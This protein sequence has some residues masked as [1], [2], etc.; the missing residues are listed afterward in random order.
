MVD[1]TSSPHAEIYW[2]DDG[3]YVGILGPDHLI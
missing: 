2:A 1:Y 3:R